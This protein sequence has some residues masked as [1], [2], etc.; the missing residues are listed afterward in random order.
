MAGTI[1]PLLRAAKRKASPSGDD[2]DS[3]LLTKIG[4]AGLSG[5]ARI[6]N[7]LDVPGAV[8]RN[9]LAGENPLAPLWH[10][11]TDE[12]RVSGRDLLRRG[13]LVGDEDTWGNWGGGLAAEIALDP[14]TYLTFGAGALTKAGKL[15]QAAGVLND[16]ARLTGKGS[17]V[18]KMTTG[19][20]H[21]A[22]LTDDAGR[23]ALEQAARAAGTSVAEHASEPL[24][25][26]ARIG[27]P[28]TDIGANV[29]TGEL[30]QKAAGYLDT[31]SDFLKG[32]APVRYARGLFDPAVMGKF[33]AAEQMVAE[34][35]H[36]VRET[37][38]RQSRLL[39]AEYMGKLSEV[40]K[41]F[42]EEFGNTLTNLPEHDSEGAV[43]SIFDRIVRMTGETGGNVEGAF[44]EIAPGAAPSESIKDS[45]RQIARD[46]QE[47]NKKVHASIEDKGGLTGWVVNHVPRY[48]A[49]SVF[50][51]QEKIQAN[52]LLPTMHSGMQARTGEIRDVPAEIVNKLVKDKGAR[53]EGAAAHIASNYSQYLNPQYE[54]GVDKHAADL[55]DWVSGH[56]Q[57]ELFDRLT[58]DDFAKYQTGAQVV[59][60]SLEAIHNV[61]KQNLGDAGVSLASAYR[62][63]WANP[64]KATEYL[65]K[66][67]GM[68][69]EELGKKKLPKDVADAIVGVLDTYQKPQW[70]ERLGQTIDKANAIFKQN[71]T[72]PFPSFWTRNL[73]SGQFV[74]MSTGLMKGPKDLAEYGDAF[75]KAMRAYRSGDSKLLSEL[76]VEGVIDQRM[77]SEGVESLGGGL[78]WE[79]GSTPN[80]L[81]VGESWKFAKQQVGEAPS[82]YGAVDTA[83]AAYGSVLRTGEKV[84]GVVEFANRAP[85]YLYLKS[86]GWSPAQAAAKVRQLQVDY[87]DLAPFERDVMKRLVP[88]YSW[89]RK[90]AP[91]I[92]G[93]LLE[94]PGG[95]MAQTIRGTRE[96]SDADATTPPYIASTLAV[97]NPF[98]TPEPGGDSFLTGFGLPFEQVAQY[99]EGP[100]AAGRELL[101]QMTPY[102][103]APLEFATG[104]SFFQTGPGGV[105][106]A[107]DDLD[108]TIGR[109]LA[110]LTGREKPV[111]T[112]GILEFAAANS[113]VSRLLTTARQLTDPR[114]TMF[115][116]AVN[117]LT[118]IREADISPAA[119]D[120]ALMDQAAQTMKHLGAREFTETYIPKDRLES[121][122]PAQRA[123]A[124]KLNELKQLIE[125]RRRSRKKNVLEF[126]ASS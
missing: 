116:K 7:T 32:K 6:G 22:S 124:D 12:G 61:V 119:K 66:I 56:K 104:Q 27:I 95:A 67:T 55:A 108:P 86:K 120:R 74:N 14:T 92:A 68:S 87:G 37:G 58:P 47:V 93:T 34:E 11:T 122:P 125:S 110:N 103:K 48:V 2:F 91:V 5:L 52:R 40:H 44:K 19:L 41:A 45:V 17:R 88:F 28:F 121:L 98:K 13:G 84:S 26:F 35:A 113:P 25:S 69:V 64:E 54:G 10:P 115:D 49:D 38:K 75:Q 36:R 42:K 77:L 100:R 18:A 83:R 43:R 21:L 81:D 24:Q 15:A 60:R 71:V 89:Q 90:I 80:P 111:R 33:D 102:V 106:R 126:A 39:T 8:V 62:K 4:S 59:D 76:F 73:T 30:A 117:A 99:A 97:P 107:L 72:L 16:A 9:A 65:S 79:L 123:L 105:G 31:A 51:R 50:G 96:A 46:M 53:G 63:A 118:G 1:N 57:K 23:T 29:G 78:G 82:G 109:T 3:G 101:S 112:P 20:G 114:K 70:M 85:L 94:R